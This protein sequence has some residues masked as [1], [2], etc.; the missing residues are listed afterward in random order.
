MSENA[1][2]AYSLQEDAIRL[3]FRTTRYAA[4]RGSVLHSG[5]YNREFSSV[6]ASF[7]LAGIA[8]FLLVMSFGKKTAFSAVFLLLFIG[9]FPLFRTY[10]FKERYYEAVFDRAS[11]TV[12]IRRSGIGSKVL[13][14]R[15]LAGISSIWID[16]ETTAIENRDGVAFV[17]KI[18]AQH[19]TVIPG[20]GQEKVF[21]T[22]KLRFSDGLEQ[23]LFADGSMQDVIAAHDRIKGFLKIS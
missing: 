21:Y 16:T 5:I 18:A 9:A 14:N 13:L 1:E 17:E 8:Y 11:A 20:F 23:A 2:R 7:A 10:I 22:L 12:E 15:P 6:L 3:A 4:D 19:G